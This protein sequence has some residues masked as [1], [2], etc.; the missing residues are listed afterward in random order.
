MLIKDDP[1]IAH[2]FDLDTFGAALR[3]GEVPPAIVKLDE[4]INADLCGDGAAILKRKDGTYWL[5]WE[6]LHPE[7]VS[8]DE[9]REAGVEIGSEERE[10]LGEALQNREYELP[11]TRAEAWAVIVGYQ[12]SGYGYDK[13]FASELKRLMR[14]VLPKKGTTWTD[15]R[16]CAR[17]G[18]K[19]RSS[20]HRTDPGP[21]G[22]GF[23][24]AWGANLPETTGGGKF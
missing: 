19:E 6:E 14:S 3:D 11:L 4:R 16:H 1:N 2:K 24:R 23:M 12:L 22:R 21:G 13:E 17:K 9:L 8:D 5:R 18:V 10:A 20:V 7:W 15:T